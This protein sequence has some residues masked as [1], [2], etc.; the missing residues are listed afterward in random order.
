[1]KEAA[2]EVIGVKTVYR[3]AG[4]WREYFEELLNVR[5]MNIQLRAEPRRE[6]NEEESPPI[7]KEEVERM[8]RK[9]KKGKV[10]GEDGLPVELIQAAG[11]VAAQWLLEICS[12]AFEVERIPDKCMRD[13]GVGGHG[14]DT[15]VYA[16]DVA[17]VAENAEGLQ[18]IVD[19][20]NLAMTQNGMKINTARSKTQFMYVSR[21][22]EE[23]DIRV[24]E[25]Q[26]K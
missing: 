25:Q 8:I 18:N 12:G 22:M 20:W 15:F 5:D 2:E 11:N 4:R 9:M 6:I 24:G 13:A 21:R 23:F 16:D 17:V 19:S 3:V 1:M 26:I 7:I 10:A 14:G